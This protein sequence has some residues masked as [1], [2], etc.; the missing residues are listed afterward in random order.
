MVATGCGRLAPQKV[1]SAVSARRVTRFPHSGPGT[2]ALK[3]TRPRGSRCARTKCSILR[4][5]T[6]GAAFASSAPPS[7]VMVR[8]SSVRGLSAS[9]PCLLPRHHHRGGVSL[10]LRTPRVAEGTG[11]GSCR[12]TSSRRSTPRSTPTPTATS[13]PSPGATDVRTWSG[14]SRTRG[15]TLSACRRSRRTISRRTSSRVSTRPASMASS[16]PRPARPWGWRA[17]ST[18]A[19]YFGSGASSA[20]QSSTASSSTR[21]H[22]ALPRPL[23]SATSRRGICSTGSS[24]TTLPWCL[25]SRSSAGTQTA[26]HP[27]FASPTP[28]STPTRI[29]RMSSSGRPIAFSWSS[30]SLFCP[31]TCHWFSVGTSTRSRRQ[32]STSSCP[33]VPCPMGT[34]TSVRTSPGSCHRRS[35]LCSTT[36][37]SCQHTQQ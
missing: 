5:R 19:P 23:P 24:K 21:L 32:R 12:T 2:T 31:E 37:A 30:S 29:F 35:K 17:R 34:Q 7:A 20:S 4:P 14:R 15:R 11:S 6:S 3:K 22:G 27:T 9:N 18:A 1:L 16:R 13:G 10:P 28:T 26:D 8:R 33:R 25:S 36:S